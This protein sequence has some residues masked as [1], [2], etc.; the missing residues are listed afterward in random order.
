MKILHISN[1]HEGGGAE[2]V[3]AHSLRALQ[4]YEPDNQRTGNTH[5]SACCTSLNPSDGY[6]PHVNLTSWTEYKLIGK[7]GYFY[8]LNNFQA[9]LKTLKEE[10]PD[11]VHLHGFYAHL[12]PSILHALRKAKRIYKFSIVQTVHSHELICANAS[13]YDWKRRSP[14]TDCMGD[15]FK[16]RIF[17]RKCDRR[18][19]LHSWAKGV[20]YLIA[21]KLLGHHSV[22]DHFVSPSE[23]VRDTLLKEGFSDQMLSVIRNPVILP[24]ETLNQ[25]KENLVVYFG[26]FSPEKNVSLLIEAMDRLTASREFADVMLNLIGEG[27]DLP[28]L[29]KLMDAKSSSGNMKIV[30]F[31][32]QKELVKIIGSAKVAVLPSTCLENAPMVIPESIS[33]GM[34]PVVTDLGGMKEMIEWLGCGYSFKSEDVESLTAAI[35]R[36]LENYTEVSDSLKVA[37][38]KIVNEL[39]SKRYV[40]QLTELYNTLENRERWP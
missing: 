15:H 24:V 12:S 23:F 1:A 14:C 31:Q 22:I 11:I 39:G 16:L 36:A 30:P 6:I 25:K 5:I 19:W 8:N 28:R 35:I 2:N 29:Q 27:E 38:G 33:M 40:Q 4:S 34:V 21:R 32:T 13:A 7:L 17:Y 10:R 26:R 3:F 37:Q 18:G 20:R 9:L